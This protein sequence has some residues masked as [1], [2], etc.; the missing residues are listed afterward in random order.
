[1]KDG[2]CFI[3]TQNKDIITWSHSDQLYNRTLHVGLLF[4][5]FEIL[6]EW[7]GNQ[8]IPSYWGT[9]DPWKCLF[10]SSNV[11]KLCRGQDKLM[12]LKKLWIL[13]LKYAL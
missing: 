5:L 13:W 3:I 2:N 4:M 6:E 1:M 10:F 8:T 7:L 11:N 9:L 12:I